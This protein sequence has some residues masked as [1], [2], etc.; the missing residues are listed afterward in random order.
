[1]LWTPEYRIL[2]TNPAK[3]ETPRNQKKIAKGFLLKTWNF[4]RI[5]LI[6]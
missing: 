6:P 4:K 3:S 1:M 2:K 5:N